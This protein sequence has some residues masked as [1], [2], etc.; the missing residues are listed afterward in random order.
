MQKAEEYLKTKRINN[1]KD[2]EELENFYIK[3]INNY[4]RDLSNIFLKYTNIKIE[5]IDL[6]M[7]QMNW[8]YEKYY[9]NEP[10]IYK[11]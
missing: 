6:Y 3:V 9:Q 7:T 10:T 5:S 8:L 2:V 11:V 4:D 1:K